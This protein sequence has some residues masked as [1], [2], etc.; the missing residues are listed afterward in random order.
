MSGYTEDELKNMLGQEPI[1]GAPMSNTVKS[2]VKRFLEINHYDGLCN[3]DCGCKLDD[4]MPCS[5]D[6]VQ[7]CEPGYIC[8]Q[9]CKE[10]EDDCE[11]REV[12]K[13]WCIRP[14]KQEA[15]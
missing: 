11:A 6:S 14:Y 4:L 8:S 12:S 2:I 1:E 9:H 7:N 13:S 10:C 5:S 3:M 15:E